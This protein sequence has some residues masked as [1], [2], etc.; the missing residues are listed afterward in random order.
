MSSETLVRERKMALDFVEEGQPLEEGQEAERV[1]GIIPKEINSKM[2]YRDVMYIA[3]PSMIELTLTQLTSMADMMMV[4]QLGPWAISSVGLTTQPKFLLMIMAMSLNVGATA[5]VA[6][7]KGAG[8]QERANLFMR[9]ALLISFFVGAIMSILGFIFSE[10]MIRFMGATEDNVL[11][12]GTAYLQIQMAGFMFMVITTTITA[13]L[14]GVGDSRTAMIYN[15]TANVINVIL[16]YALIYGNWGLPKMGVAGASLATIIGQ[17]AAFLLAMYAIC[18]GNKYLHLCFSDGFKPDREAVSSIAKIG[19]PAMVEQMVMRT[20]M[21]LFSKIVATLGTVSFATHQ[22]CMNIQAMSFMIGQAYQISA[23]SLVGQSLGKIRSDMAQLYAN[24][25][26]RIGMAVSLV[27]AVVFLLFGKEIVSLYS[28]DIT[29]IAQGGV[30]MFFM[31]F[32]LPFQSSQFILT[33]A[34]R[35]AGDTRSTAIISLLTILILRPTIAYVCINY[36][37]FGLWGAWIALACDQL[38]RSGLVFMRF[39]SG[40]WKKIKA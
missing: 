10:D 29:I 36:F 8:Q 15:M 25:T 18:S 14:R 5:M 39:S 12:A 28:D 30:I 4:G 6:R 23:T 2:L 13:V 21:I 26:R 31:A 40:R 16:N 19:I 24:C 20:G 32:I 17:F 7:S 34:L 11:Q 33:G 3:L 1:N 37:G 9:Q 27:L 38:V 35:G 22:I